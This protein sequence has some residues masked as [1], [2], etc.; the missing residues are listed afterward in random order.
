M[1]EQPKPE[2]LKMEYEQTVQTLRNWDTLF[3][4]MFSSVVVAGA[5][6][7]AIAWEGAQDATR[8]RAILLI[9]PAVMYGLTC[10]YFLYNLLVAR[11]KFEV[12]KEI[13]ERLNLVGAYG[14]L[15]TRTNKIMYWGFLPFFTLLYIACL[16]LV[17]RFVH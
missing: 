9:V 3:F 7:G 13:E 8:L 5:I 11:R 6:G 12:L 4:G 14:R 10:M 1:T 16:S 15:T 2:H 17:L